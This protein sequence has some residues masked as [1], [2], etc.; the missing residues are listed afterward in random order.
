[1]EG[2]TIPTTKTSRRRRILINCC[3]FY[4]FIFFGLVSVGAIKLRYLSNEIQPS[5][6]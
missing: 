1:M 3:H 2:V 5:K 4:F 6:N